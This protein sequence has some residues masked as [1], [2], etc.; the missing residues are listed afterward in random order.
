MSCAPGWTAGA[1][2]ESGLAVIPVKSERWARAVRIIPSCYPPV[3]L[4]D[5]V[6]RPEDLD[7]VF[8]VEALTNP[9]IRQQVGNLSLV[10]PEERISGPGTTPIMAAFTH[11]NT[12]G[13]R[14]SPGSYGVYY[15]ADGEATAVA[16]TRY[17]RERFYRYQDVGPQRI[18]MRAYVGP[19]EAEWADL[20]GLR[21]ARADLYDPDSYAASQ[22]FGE[23]LREGGA[24]GIAYES[25]R[26]PEGQCLAVFRPRA[27]AAVRQGPHYEYFYDGQQITHVVR[28]TEIAT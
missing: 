20:R 23:S 27:C 10:P 22:P 12:A 8:A 7:A 2:G 15:A 24:W 9:R 17:H 28:L 4:F 16:E 11:P 6:A 13:S 14:F 19:A 21:R 3:G 1:A 26:R 18:Q 5:E 25:L